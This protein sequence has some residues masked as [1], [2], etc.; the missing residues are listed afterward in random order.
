MR[1]ID[2]VINKLK[3]IHIESFELP[4][5]G[6][7]GITGKSGSGKSTILNHIH[8]EQLSKYVGN[9]ISYMTQENT[10]F[11]HLNVKDNICFQLSLVDKVF[12]ED[13]P[14]VIDFDIKYLLK[15]KIR[16]LS[17]G[18]RQRVQFVIMML[19]KTKIILLDEPTASLNDDFISLMKSYLLKI[20]DECLVIVTSHNPQIFEICD[21]IYKIDNN[22]LM[23]EK[24]KV[25]TT[26]LHSTKHFHFKHLPF[27]LRKFGSEL[28]RNVPVY[29]VIAFICTGLTL[30]HSIKYQMLDYHT[31]LMKLFS[32]NEMMLMN[33]QDPN[34]GI[35]YQNCMPIN[36][37]EWDE[38]HDIKGIH[39]YPLYYISNRSNDY[40]EQT[41]HLNHDEKTQYD[42][43]NVSVAI[44]P[45]FDTEWLQNNLEIGDVRDDGIYMRIGGYIDNYEEIFDIKNNQINIDIDV[46]IPT[47]YAIMEVTNG[48]FEDNK[49]YEWEEAA[50]YGEM[51][52]FQ[53][54]LDGIVNSNYGRYTGAKIDIHVPYDM[55]MKMID[56]YQTDEPK[57]FFGQ[58]MQ[59]FSPSAAYIYLDDLQNIEEIDEQI[60]KISPFFQTTYSYS[61]YEKQTQVY[62]NFKNEIDIFE[63]SGIIFSLAL[64][65]CY[66]KLKRQSDLSIA[67]K[68]YLLKVRHKDYLKYYFLQCLLD[69]FMILVLTLTMSMIGFYILLSVGENLVYDVNA[70][71]AALISSFVLSFIMKI[72]MERKMLYDRNM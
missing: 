18:E 11:D 39:C 19:R 2:I 48:N 59:P 45:Y 60:Q 70:T 34:G 51:Y 22:Q 44:V 67:H 26:Y 12:V 62:Q 71:I 43:D 5:H 66:W 41:L 30:M 49:K 50:L 1:N 32:Q 9:H 21:V 29:F 61:D 20:K 55:Y 33:S 68:L 28:F 52:H 4:D 47:H 14:L 65:Y 69:T 16:D 63:Y 15:K 46:L 24:G 27:T 23:Q 25:Q 38:L 6:I 40:V 42:I 37:E 3:T 72:V 56:K 58:I 7:V 57:V 13:D 35:S 31:T 10:F 17:V 36:S 64:G 54:K 8:H 53:G